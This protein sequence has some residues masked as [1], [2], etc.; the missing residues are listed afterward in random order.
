MSIVKNFRNLS[1]LLIFQH[2]TKNGK[3]TKTAFDF[4]S[5]DNKNRIK[6]AKLPKSLKKNSEI[7]IASTE[8]NNLRDLES[9]D[10]NI[11]DNKNG[12][13]QVVNEEKE[14][15]WKKFEQI[16][17]HRQKV[18]RRK[19]EKYEVDVEENYGAEEVKGNG[20]EISQ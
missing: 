12:N 8:D 18:K 16:W 14:E 2:L 11:G 9:D 13:G 7:D 10:D 3:C 1:V 19:N 5:K 4:L 17:A 20:G 6:E 15:F